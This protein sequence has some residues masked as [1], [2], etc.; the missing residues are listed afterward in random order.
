MTTPFTPRR[1]RSFVGTYRPRIDALEK[2]SGQAEYLDDVAQGNRFPGMLHAKILRSPFPHARIARLDTARAAAVPGVHDVLTFADPEVA[3]L[4]STSNAWTSANTASYDQMYFPSLHD[5]QVL[6]DGA[7][8]VGDE[9]GVVVAAETEAQAA[10]AL[11]QLDI[12]W[13]VRPFVLDLRAA[14]A[15]EA[16]AIHPEMNPGGNVL[17]ADPISGRAMLVDKGNV[18][19]AS[20]D[21]TSWSRWPP[22]TIARITLASTPGA[23]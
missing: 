1:P 11:R 7:T 6:G 12:E 3:A 8:W 16:P 5:R 20:D 23:A 15:D 10:E 9:S 17:P 22:A 19:A 13:E 18:D 14:L 21:A 2:A 4:K